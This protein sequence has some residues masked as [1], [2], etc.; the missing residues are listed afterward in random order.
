[1]ARKYSKKVSKK[2]GKIMREYKHGKLKIGRS[3]RKVKS[4][5]Q[6]VAIALSQA[7]KSGAKVP[8]KR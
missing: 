4:K 8:F 2:V 1:M 6:A 3:G 7:R 5:E